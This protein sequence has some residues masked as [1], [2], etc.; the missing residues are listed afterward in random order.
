MHCILSPKCSALVDR[1]TLRWIL[2]A[3]RLHFPYVLRKRPCGATL[4]RT[5]YRTHGR[6]D[7]GRTYGRTDRGGL[8][9]PRIPPHCFRLRRYGRRNSR[10]K[11]FS[12]EKVFGRQKFRPKNLSTEMFFGRNQISTEN[13]SVEKLF[14]RKNFW[15]KKFWDEVFFGQKSFRPFEDFSSKSEP[16]LFGA[17]TCIA[18]TALRPCHDLS[19][20][21]AKASKIGPPNGPG[22]ALGINA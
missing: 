3:R 22:T 5:N 21:V 6:G 17:S 11:S 8:P 12:V 19:K 10:P 13:N 14:G 4:N 2:A 20:S 16:V 15:P 7:L 18:E 1:D 9:P